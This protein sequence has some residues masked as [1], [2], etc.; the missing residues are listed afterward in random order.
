MAALFTIMLVVSGTPASA[1]ASGDDLERLSLEDLLNIEITSVS[2]RTE[3]M[4]DA[5]A[6][7]YVLTNNDIR[8]SG[9][10]TIPDVLRLVPGV[11]VGQIDSNTWSVSVRGFGGRFSNKLLVLVDGRSVYTP[12]FSGVFWNLVYVPLDDVERIEIVRGP[13]ATLWGANAVNGVVNI[14]TRSAAASKGGLVTVGT[15]TEAHGLGSFRYGGAVGAHANL[16]V[17]VGGM[18]QAGAA[19]VLPSG[20][21]NDWRVGRA[22][23]RLDYQPEDHDQFS[24]QVGVVGSRAHELWTVPSLTPPYQGHAV[25]RSRY[26][27]GFLLGQW[28]RRSAKSETTL[29]MSD[30]HGVMH[31]LVIDE[32]RHT[33]NVDLQQ[34]R[35]MGTR[36]EVVYGGTYRYSADETVGT[37]TAQLLPNA[38][39]LQLW[40]TFVQDD[41]TIL[42]GRL[43]LTPGAK[44]EHNDY[45]GWEVQPSLRAFVGVSRRQ[46][47]WGAVS[48]AVRLPTR[49]ESDGRFEAAV[50]PPSPAAPLPQLLILSQ[51]GGS[52]DSETLV[53]SEAGYRVRP[54][55]TLSIDAAVFTN[56]YDALLLGQPGTPGV[57]FAPVP[58]VVV[59]VT[60][61]NGRRDTTLGGEL[62]VEWRPAPRVR[63]TSGYSH[64]RKLANDAPDGVSG[65]VSGD[66]PSDQLHFR[67]SANLPRQVELDLIT[68]YVSAMPSS[69]VL[70]Y[71]T[72][73]ARLGARIGRLDVS[74]VGQNLLAPSHNEYMPDVLLIVPSS[75]RRSINVLFVSRF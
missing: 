62:L 53:A 38:R 10:R 39:S 6:A 19:V 74:V 37:P 66:Y 33:V 4:S 46:S 28:T 5:A 1:Q 64:F 12:L 63:L 23:F 70:S 45:T 32:N 60:F 16:R 49:A 18:E 61:A 41:I 56:R 55:S 59:P 40:S 75:V 57:A 69:T 3:R 24:V 11:H 8:R 54:V 31:E 21:G 68:R 50:L 67:A 51:N 47:L 29:Q 72:A 30:E 58:H 9:A 36:H 25:D 71:F 34:T 13:G 44:F 43:R 7:V 2:R 42:A 52:I 14:I 27:S 15:G 22:G 20:T 26:T 17:D 35:R 48:R 65:L 73:D